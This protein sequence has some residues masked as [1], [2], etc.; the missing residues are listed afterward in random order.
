MVC[1][2]CIFPGSTITCTTAP[3]RKRLKCSRSG[4]QAEVRDRALRHRR[5]TTRISNGV[6]SRSVAKQARASLLASAQEA[7]LWLAR[8]CTASAQCRGGSRGRPMRC[9]TVAATRAVAASRP[10]PEIDNSVAQA[11][12]SRTA[13][14]SSRS[15][16]AMRASSRRISSSSCFI[17][18]R[19]SVGMSEP[20]SASSL[21]ICSVPTRLPSAMPRLN[22][23]QQPR[24]ACMRAV[25]VASQA[26]R[27]PCRR[28]SACSRRAQKCA[29]PQAS[30]TT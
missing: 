10:T 19:S 26:E 9:E 12:D 22:S 4:T 23:R 6:W 29:E 2:V 16:W 14:A 24:R 18:A 15:S 8:A 17:G 30:M 3:H 21:A 27:T 13:A 28:C 11:A 5:G 1:A 7:F 25:R 20:G